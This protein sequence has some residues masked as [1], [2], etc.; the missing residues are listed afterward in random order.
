MTV[1]DAD[2]HVVTRGAESL[3][4]I[5]SVLERWPEQVSV[6]TDGV[7]GLVIEGRG[8]PQLDGP[9]AGCPPGSG[10]VEG[11]ISPATPDGML[12][13]AARDGIDEMVLFPGFGHF[14]LSITDE[15]LAVDVARSYNQWLADFCARGHGRLH[16]A[17]VLPIDFPAAAA[18]LAGES[19]ALGLVAGVIPPAPRTGNLDSRAFDEVYAAAVD[20]DLPLTVH[21]GPGV[22]LEKPGYDRF[23]NYIQV[24]CVSFPFEQMVA[25]TALV[26]GGVFERHPRLRCALLEAGAGWL[27][28]FV[29]RLH[30]HWERRGDW[31]PGGWRRPPAEYVRAGNLYV[32]CESDERMLPAVIDALGADCLMFAS[33]YPH[34][35][36]A[37]PEST[38]ALRERADIDADAREAILSGNARRFY[39]LPTP[40]DLG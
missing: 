30:E 16:G 37:W 3:E 32:T 14:A 6:R 28:Y 19:R 33:D 31:I 36:S 15:K 10:L 24:H 23:T 40:A 1:I 2:A 8:Y 25:M 17:A 13:D 11:D 7:P 29:E 35:D 21:G 18:E 20:A 9:G 4:L 27:P 39:G 5:R 12:A 26:T 22:H 34:W 38:R